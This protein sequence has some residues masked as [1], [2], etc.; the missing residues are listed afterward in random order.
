MYKV[1]KI[2][3]VVLAVVA[4]ILYGGLLY[5]GV[6]PF[7]GFMFNIAYILTIIAVLAVLVYG[8]VNLLSSPQKLKKTLIYTGAFLGII[9]LSY[10]LAKG[11]GTDKWVGTGITAFFILG[12]LASA[13]MVF[14]GIKGALVK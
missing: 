10:V 14:S 2:V 6:D 4:V 7:T 11:E 8:L 12:G 13:L 5:Q 9:L 3:M 1:T